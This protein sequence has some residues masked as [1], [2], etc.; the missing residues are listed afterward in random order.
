MN[1]FNSD[2]PQEGSVS[3]DEGA[4]TP[5]DLLFAAEPESETRYPY[6]D[7]ETFGDDFNAADDFEVGSMP[8]LMA[9]GIP[10]PVDMGASFEPTAPPPPAPAKSVAKEK[11]T[12]AEMAAQL[13]NTRRRKP[14]SAT[15]RVS[16][17]RPPS[18]TPKARYTPV[19]PTGGLEPAGGVFLPYCL[20]VSGIGG[21]VYFALIAGSPVFAGM[22][23]TLGLV[24]AMF[25]RVL[26]RR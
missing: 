18:A 8:N 6:D 20:V 19:A 10:E 14:P 17:S 9:S 15:G 25:C 23:F 26:L 4:A 12:L 1:L 13:P 22:S 11:P 3:N 2:R 7:E 5:E 21:G 16:Y 24:G